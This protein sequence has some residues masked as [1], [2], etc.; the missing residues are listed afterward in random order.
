MQTRGEL[1][2]C[3]DT[4]SLSIVGSSPLREREEGFD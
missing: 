4:V 3:V 2:Q 1:D